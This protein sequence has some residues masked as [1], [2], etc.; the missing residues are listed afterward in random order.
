MAD[1]RIELPKA[2]TDR[3]TADLEFR[4]DNPLPRYSRSVRGSL[5]ALPVTRL[6]GGGSGTEEILGYLWFADDEDGAGF[7]T[8]VLSPEGRN[9]GGMWYLRLRECKARGLSPA[10][11]RSEIP[12][13][14]LSKV[15]GFADLERAF[16]GGSLA[17]LE[18]RAARGE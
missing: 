1:E 5:V 16:T 11:A 7:V 2:A 17:E 6:G 12:K 9:A 14:D 8:S 4:I 15:S 13:G 18:S 10:S 3:L